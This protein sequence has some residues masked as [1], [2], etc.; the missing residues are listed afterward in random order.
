MRN[1]NSIT[2][3]KFQGSPHIPLWS[4]TKHQCKKSATG[5][6]FLCLCMCVQT[7]CNNNSRQFLELLTMLKFI[8][9][10]AYCLFRDSKLGSSW[11]L[12]P[13]HGSHVNFR[14]G[15]AWFI[16]HGSKVNA[17]RITAYRFPNCS[18]LD[19]LCEIMQ[20]PVLSN[21]FSIVGETT[22]GCVFVVGS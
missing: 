11:V 1:S 19:L 10:Q 15:L 12:A 14:M 8:T 17:V 6:Y 21:F 16:M 13:F 5:P 7:E 4:I 9:N 22:A 18:L 2:T 20:A 3:R